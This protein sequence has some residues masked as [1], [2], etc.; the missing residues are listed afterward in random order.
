[1]EPYTQTYKKING[2]EVGVIRVDNDFYGNPRFV[3]WYGDVLRLAG[4][5]NND[6]LESYEEAV[7][8]AKDKI[9]GKKYRVKWFGGGIVFTSY[10]V[11]EDLKRLIK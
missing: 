9:G 3:I 7:K 2:E 1:M 11:E 6:I 5:E 10:N 4:I 8:I